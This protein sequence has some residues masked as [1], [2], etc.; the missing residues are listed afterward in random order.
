MPR[1]IDDVAAPLDL[2]IADYDMVDVAWMDDV[3]DYDVTD[4][5][6]FFLDLAHDEN[7][8]F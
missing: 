7:F 3:M 6:S 4:G 2:N 8:Q 1:S 5:G